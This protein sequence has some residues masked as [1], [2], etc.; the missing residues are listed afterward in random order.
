[1]LRPWHKLPD[2]GMFRRKLPKILTLCLMTAA[3][4]RNHCWIL[5]QQPGQHP[6]SQILTGDKLG[7][8]LASANKS[9]LPHNNML[10]FLVLPPFE[11]LYKGF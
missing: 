5:K 7:K 8:S 11:M 6:T 4:L 10:I 2:A 3:V 9:N 1:M